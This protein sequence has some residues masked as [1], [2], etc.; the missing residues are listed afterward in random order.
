ML[1]KQE[2]S[3]PSSPLL[4]RVQN[5]RLDNGNWQANRMNTGLLKAISLTN[6]EISNLDS[7]AENS[8]ASTVY[9]VPSSL[10][11]ADEDLR[12]MT[13]CDPSMEG[14]EGDNPD[15]WYGVSR[16][17]NST[18]SSSPTINGGIQQHDSVSR[19]ASEIER[20]RHPVT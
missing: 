8:Q 2:S 10:R 13:H 7:L 9:H 17:G 1:G 6:R 19:T 5:L 16:I 15:G 18:P 20:R 12:M 11:T 4:L 14:F 3:Q